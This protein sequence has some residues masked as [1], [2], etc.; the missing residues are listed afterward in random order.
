MASQTRLIW[1]EPGCQIALISAERWSAAVGD[2]V[3]I[4]VVHG[5]FLFSL[6]TERES[7]WYFLVVLPSDFSS[8]K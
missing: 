1:S 7:T 4:C 6:G 8:I 3:A 2:E 5:V